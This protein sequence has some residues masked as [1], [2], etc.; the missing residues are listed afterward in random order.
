L[1]ENIPIRH[2]GLG[3]GFRGDL[4]YLSGGLK[5]SVG[6]LSFLLYFSFLSFEENNCI[7]KSGFI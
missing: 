3:G 5:V 4:F 1:N 7:S 6:L 2:L